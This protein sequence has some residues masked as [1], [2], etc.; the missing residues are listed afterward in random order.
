MSEKRVRLLE[1]LIEISRSL[2]STLSLRQLL[3]RIVTTAQELTRAEASSI[4]LVD[5]GSGELRFKAATNLPGIRSIA[6]PM[7]G[8]VAGWVVRKG[9]SL[10]VSDPHSDSRFYH[11]AD[12]QS[13]FDTRSLLAVPL[14]AR[15]NVSGA[16]EAVNKKGG[17]EFTEEDVE[18]LTV[19]GDQA[20]V[21]VQNALLFQQTD[22]I[23]EIVHEMRTPLTS[24]ISYADL[25][26]RPNL[27]QEQQQQFADVIR[28]E[29]ERLNHMAESYLDLAQLESGRAPLAQDPVDL[30]TVTYMAANVLRPKADANQI[31]LCVEVPE[32]LPSVMGDAQ[33]L[34]RALL[35]LLDNAV[36]YSQPGDKVRVTAESTETHLK[37]SVAD[38]GPGIP[39]EELPHIFERFYR[40][41]TTEREVSGAGLGL[42]L[43][44]Q[45]IEAHKGGIEVNS[46]RGRGTTFTFTLPVKEAQQ[47]SRYFEK[48]GSGTD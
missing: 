14:I 28:G 36:K 21:A 45:I 34:H 20:A 40:G 8:S 15:G 2:N 43:T 31:Q 4:L 17:N 6:V 29:A 13:D 12:E 46:E 25:I 47:Q 30:N 44:Q 39:E 38:T 33:R 27:A 11:Q 35:N 24:I 3:H 32:D 48:P 19:L 16:L 9:E 10:I 42:A 41:S 22:L 26:Q 18:L 37:V 5:R 7:E 1:Q 23:S